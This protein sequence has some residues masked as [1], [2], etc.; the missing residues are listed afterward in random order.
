M[1]NGQ[2]KPLNSIV[3]YPERGSGGNNKYRGKR[4]REQQHWKAVA[5]T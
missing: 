2:N 3:S 5:V 1:S 4:S